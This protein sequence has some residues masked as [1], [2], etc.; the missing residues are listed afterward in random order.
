MP[1]G[2]TLPPRH[3]PRHDGRSTW[4]PFRVIRG[5]HTEPRQPRAPYSFPGPALSPH[6]QCHKP[7]PGLG[8][9]GIRIRLRRF[10]SRALY[11]RR[12]LAVPHLPS[13]APRRRISAVPLSS[14]ALPFALGTGLAVALAPWFDRAEM[15][16]DGLLVPALFLGTAMSIT[17]FPVLARIIAERGLQKDRMG[18]IAVACAAIQDFLAWIVLAVVV[19]LA[20]STDPGPSPGC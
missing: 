2:I 5:P 8:I 15:T 17:A 3:R 4:S 9:A 1:R 6:V 10:L 12:R 19:A 11:V 20:E 7:T 16:T 14:V 18:S 13:A